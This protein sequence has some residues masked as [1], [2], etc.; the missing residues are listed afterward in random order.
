MIKN[1]TKNKREFCCRHVNDGY[2]L[3]ELVFY[4]A[5]FTILSIAVLNALMTMTK[6]FKETAINLELSQ[7]ASIVERIAREIR[8]AE[9]INTIS[10]SDLTLNTTDSGGASQTVRFLLSSSNLQFFENGGLVGNLNTADLAV[11]A[12][13][14]TEITT[15][16]GE[17]VRFVVTVRSLNDT[18]NRI[19]DF[20]NTI[21]LRGGY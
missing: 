5:L 18:L 12:L 9:S 4:I 6:A 16:E 1:H 15:T 14:F 20:N 3:L 8:R 19:I 13:S 10:A 2:S 7:G 17:A 21:V 11:T